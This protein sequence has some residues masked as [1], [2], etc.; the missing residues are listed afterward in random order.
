MEVQ[1]E[2]V[3]RA[4]GWA[5]SPWGVQ[6]EACP[7]PGPIR[8]RPPGLHHFAIKKLLPYTMSLLVISGRFIGI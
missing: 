6:E 4:L 7:D 1:P 3:D 2:S 5:G 8:S